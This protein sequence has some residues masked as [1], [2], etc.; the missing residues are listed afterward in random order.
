LKYT[1]LSQGHRAKTLTGFA[2]HMLVG[3]ANRKPVSFAARA[4]L[5]GK[6]WQDLIRRTDLP[7][8]QETD[9]EEPAGF[10]PPY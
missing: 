8:A 10:D 9:E 6:S 5:V 7:A 3:L 4:A 2:A 1:R